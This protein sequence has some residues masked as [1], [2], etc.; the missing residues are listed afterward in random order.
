MRRQRQ[1]GWR[2]RQARGLDT[3]VWIELCLQV[4]LLYA[5]RLQRVNGR[6]RDLVPFRNDARAFHRSSGEHNIRDLQ[7]AALSQLF[8][9][10]SCNHGQVT[11]LLHLPFLWRFFILV[12]SS[13]NSCLSLEHLKIPQLSNLHCLVSMLRFHL[14]YPLEL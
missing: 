5:T 7:F 4:L 1:N 13:S 14:G 8:C 3:K 6:Q 11:Q 2:I 9:L 10:A 12:S